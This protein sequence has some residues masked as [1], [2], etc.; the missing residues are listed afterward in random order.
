MKVR[1]GSAWEKEGGGVRVGG[2]GKKRLSEDY[3]A[4]WICLYYY[5]EIGI[6]LKKTLAPPLLLA[7][8]KE[9]GRGGE[10]GRG[11]EEEEEGRRKRK[12]RRWNNL[13]LHPNTL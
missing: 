4:K 5:P 12:R 10:R 3:V 7:E 2:R 8:I 11:R 1:L 6:E 9:S 13:R